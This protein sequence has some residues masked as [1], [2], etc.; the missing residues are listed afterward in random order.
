MTAP[1]LLRHGLLLAGLLSLVSCTTPRQT[2]TPVP[3]PAPSTQSAASRA[4]SAKAL[5]PP[6]PLPV[7]EAVRPISLDAPEPPKP[8]RSTP[9]SRSDQIIRLVRS[10]EVVET[11]AQL[12]IFA[13]PRPSET[14]PGGLFEDAIVLNRLRGGLKKIPGLPPQVSGSATVS[15]ARAFLQ[16]GDLVSA[17]LAAKAI[18]AALR[19]DGITQVH[20]TLRD[21]VRM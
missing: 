19:T 8:S 11:S 21:S 12:V 17:E 16:L 15:R 5:R 3:P 10:G 13:A 20:A 9:P 14:T 4:V 6:P 1:F 7:P 18:D 2:T